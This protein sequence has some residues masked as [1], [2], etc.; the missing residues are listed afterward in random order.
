MVKSTDAA[1]FSSYLLAVTGFLALVPAGGGS[2][3]YLITASVV[4]LVWAVVERRTSSRVPRNVARAVDLLCATSILFLAATH[5]ALART[6]LVSLG[7]VLVVAQLGRAF[8][9]K[10]PADYALFHGT[11][12]GQIA[13][14]AFLTRDPIFLPLLVLAVVL[15]A[16]ASLRVP[17]RPLPTGTDVRIFV[18]RPRGRA[19]FRARLGSALQPGFLAL[20]VLLGGATLFVLLPR[21][22]QFEQ[23]GDNAR[24]RDV[25]DPTDYSADREEAADRVTGFS[26]HVRLGEIGRIR[27]V[28]REAF[29]VQ[30]L[31]KGRP[32]ALREWLMYFKGGVHDTFNGTSWERSEE[33][34]GGEPHYVT[35]GDRRGRLAVHAELRSEVPG[36]GL[37]EQ[38]YRFRA[39]TSPIL[40]SLDSLVSIDLTPDMAKVMPLGA[41]SFAAPR[42]HREG[43]EY[44]VTSLVALDPRRPV[45]AE[46]LSVARAGPY[47]RLPEGSERLAA[48][49]RRVAGSGDALEKARLLSAWLGTECEYT[50]QSN[51][52]PS[53]RPVEEFLFETKAGHCEYF[54]SAFTLLLRAVGVPTR[55]V[56]G[57][58]GGIW[59]EE[60]ESYFVTQDRA[61]AWT[62]VHVDGRGW[63]RFDPTPADDTAVT[64]PTARVP[65]TNPEP[66]SKAITRRLLSFVQDFGPRDRGKVMDGAKGAFG[67]VMEEGFGFGREERRFPPPLLVVVIGAA[68]GWLV[69]KL[70]RSRPSRGKGG[71]GPARKRSAPK[72]A[73]T[74]FYEEALRNLALRGYPRRA[75]Q[76]PREFLSAVR[77]PLA[78]AGPP[79]EEITQ[80]FERVRYGC[81]PLPADREERLAGLAR[82]LARIPVDLKDA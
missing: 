34:K 2:A 20:A 53:A 61:H 47:L 80:W 23:P 22:R 4:L 77:D 55:L 67:F 70:L 50:L 46:D 8:R 68:G 26:D 73:P 11:A 19:G 40:F 58:R 39:S 12:F 78:E 25:F 74:P 30:L 66:A 62:E 71:T 36:T 37:Y 29:R 27:Q 43:F 31:R 41:D 52:Q 49:A 32:A 3:P 54:A 76:S 1:P 60:E 51:L 56:V 33:M 48:L 72:R 13:L 28:P 82:G 81:A 6:S 17:A 16:I 14:A 42:P 35:T 9:Q 79:F 21:G 15:A 7:H 18:A 63:V 75:A 45:L 59:L 69:L 5:F 57:Y 24:R 65:G 44:R 38:R 64:V 10:T